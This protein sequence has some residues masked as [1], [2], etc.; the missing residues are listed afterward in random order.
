MSKED[1]KNIDWQKVG[2][3]SYDNYFSK[4]ISRDDFKKYLSE[5]HEIENDALKKTIARF[6]AGI[7]QPQ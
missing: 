5:A 3:E 6:K 4:S 7:G 1:R 2:Y